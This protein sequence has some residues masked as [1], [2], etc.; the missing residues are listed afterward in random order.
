[1][2]WFNKVDFAVAEGPAREIGKCVKRARDLNKLS[3]PSVEF[4]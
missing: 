4:V 2:V 1:M 3:Q